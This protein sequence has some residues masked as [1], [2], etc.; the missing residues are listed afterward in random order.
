MTIELLHLQ[1]RTRSGQPLGVVT[2]V[3]VD[4]ETQTIRQYTVRRRRLLTGSTKTL[5]IDRRQVVGFDEDGMIV[6]DASVPDAAP[7]VSPQPA[8]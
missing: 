7:S 6:E 5:L 3:S 4:A 2:D 1:V 8:T